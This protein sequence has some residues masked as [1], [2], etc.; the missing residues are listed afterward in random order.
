[1]LAFIPEDMLL[2]VLGAMENSP[3]AKIL[4]EANLIEKL[5]SP[6]GVVPLALYVMEQRRDPES[7]WKDYLETLPKDWSNQLIFWTEEEMSWL[8]GSEIIGYVKQFKQK[9]EHDYALIS[10]KIEGFSTEFSEREF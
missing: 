4:K 6:A 1:M 8:K 3:N 9:L 7:P 2:T 5:K 10:E